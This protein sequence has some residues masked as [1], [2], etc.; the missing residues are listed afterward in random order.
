LEKEN[1]G[2]ARQLHADL[3]NNNKKQRE[4]DVK[5]EPLRVTKSVEGAKLRPIN[6]ISNT[7]NE[8][9]KELE[10]R[11]ASLHKKLR[12]SS[13]EADESSRKSIGRDRLLGGGK[14]TKGGEIESLNCWLLGMTNQAVKTEHVSF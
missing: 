13:L 10:L 4:R 5:G 3:K 14:K 1:L 8:T 11:D 12:G 9:N 7:T 2:D 6:V